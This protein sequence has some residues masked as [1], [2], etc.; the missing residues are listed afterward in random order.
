VRSD[1]RTDARTGPPG[2]VAVAPAARE[3]APPHGA[4]TS[5]TAPAPGRENNATTPSL[6]RPG[7][8][9]T[10]TPVRPGSSKHAGNGISGNGGIRPAPQAR[11]QP[12]AV[13]GVSP[14][15]GVSPAQAAAAVAPRKAE[16]V[17]ATYR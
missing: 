13:P 15:R 9:A 16:P 8:A 3:A 4:S 10:G 11:A 17:I 1:T 5:A 7:V 6:P 12:R 2:R 14:N